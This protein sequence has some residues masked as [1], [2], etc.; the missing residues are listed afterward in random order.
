LKPIKNIRPHPQL[1]NHV[2]I[3][4][5]D[6]SKNIASKAILEQLNLLHLVEAKPTPKEQ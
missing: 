4:F 3:S 1:P 2:L 5:E 6:G